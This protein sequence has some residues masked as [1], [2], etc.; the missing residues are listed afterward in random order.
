MIQYQHTQIWD[1]LDVILRYTYN[2]DDNSSQFIPILEYDIGDHAQ[3]FLIGRQSF[4]SEDTE[5]RSVL[6]YRWILGLQYTF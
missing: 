4:G 5:F 1:V 3:L 6:D 2:L